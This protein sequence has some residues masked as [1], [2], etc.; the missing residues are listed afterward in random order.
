[1]IDHCTTLW[2]TGG[3][4]DFLAILPNLSSFDQ[5]WNNT[6][7]NRDLKFLLFSSEQMQ[8]FKKV[9]VIQFN[10]GNFVAFLPYR[11]C[12]DFI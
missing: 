11:L 7:S 10:K 9:G 4:N 12:S 8:S 3:D 1:M 5:I 2:A 6:Q